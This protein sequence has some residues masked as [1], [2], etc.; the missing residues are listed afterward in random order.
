VIQEFE[1]YQKQRL[2]NLR[3]G[4]GKIIDGLKTDEIISAMRDDPLSHN[5]AYLR[6]REVVDNLLLAESE[7]LIVNLRQEV[8]MLREKVLIVEA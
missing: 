6:M 7:Q 1:I 4:L 8:V 2:L 5:F 3:E